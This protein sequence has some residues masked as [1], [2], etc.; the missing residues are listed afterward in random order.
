MSPQTKRLISERTLLPL[1]DQAPEYT[2]LA[3]S[4][5]KAP[6]FHVSIYY[7]HPSIRRQHVR[8]SETRL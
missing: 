1:D 4:R 3:L 6:E 5:H 7:R 8:T 2:H